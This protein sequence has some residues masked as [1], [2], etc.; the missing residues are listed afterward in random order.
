ME[1]R[2]ATFNDAQRLFEWR[3]D[4]LTRAMFK[5]S[6]IV[7]WHSHVDWLTARLCRTNPNLFIAEVSGRAV[8]TFRVDDG[9]LS[10]TIAPDDRG[11]GFGREMLVKVREMFGPMRAEIYE[12]NVASMKIAAHAGH[13]IILLR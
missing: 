9:E 4:P 8:G 7:E 11:R 5:N 6:D 12:R 3:N 10:Y 13:A 2:P 1:I